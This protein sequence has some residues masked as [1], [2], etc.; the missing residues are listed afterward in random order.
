MLIIDSVSKNLS[1]WVKIKSIIYHL[2]NTTT[3]GKYT[4][5]SYLE[6]PAKGALLLGFEQSVYNKRCLDDLVA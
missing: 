5:L 3:K 4:T 1:R 2:R 6:H